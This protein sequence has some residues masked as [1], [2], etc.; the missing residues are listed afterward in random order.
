[1]L[2]HSSPRHI[3]TVETIS[4]G[5]QQERDGIHTNHAYAVMRIIHW[6]M[7]FLTTGW[8]P[9][10]DKPSL[11]SSLASTVPKAGHQFT[12]LSAR[13]AIRKAMSTSDRS[14]SDMLSQS[15]AVNVPSKWGPKWG[16][17]CINGSMYYDIRL[18]YIYPGFNLVW[19][20][21][22]NF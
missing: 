21:R 12:S 14:C 16:K 8:P 18:G 4:S 10:S 2:T 11:T 22:S 20:D 13:Y 19:L 6:R 15:V 9:R 1:M 7:V 5:A 3:I 17:L